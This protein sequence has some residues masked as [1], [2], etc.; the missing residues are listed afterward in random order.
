MP[1]RILP[2]SLAT[3]EIIFSGEFAFSPE[4]LLSMWAAGTAAA[5]AAVA[6]WRI[7]GP[8]YTWLTAGSVSG[9]GLAA[10][11]LD[12]HPGAIVGVAGAVLA[13]WAARHPIA[14]AALLGLSA[15]GSLTAAA[16]AG[17]WP[18]AVTGAATLGGITGEML[19][20]HWYLVSPQMPRW[21]LRRL[22]VAGGVGLAL[23]A[24][25]LA[26]AGFLVGAGGL[27]G[28]IFAM[29]AGVSIL[30]MTAVWFALRE[31]GYEGVMA[32]TGLSYLAVLTAL[33]ATAVGRVLL[34]GDRSFL[35]LG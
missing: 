29:L 8:G 1:L 6:W 14:T 27:G 7:V 35:P 24:I 10:V 21:A 11:L 17:S 25:L 2:G 23:D 5:G 4:L 16:S 31:Q 33:G 18:L 12:P 32:A 30:L 3:A 34:S 26:L 15:A 28:W 13:V 22:D 9:I 19:L 20:G